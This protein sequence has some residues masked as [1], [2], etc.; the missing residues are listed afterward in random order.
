MGCLGHAM[1]STFLDAA[2]G[3]VAALMRARDWSASPLGAP[4]G[5]PA[6]LQTIASLVLH[7]TTPMFVAWGPRR[8]MLY[9]DAYLSILGD[10]HPAALG[11]PAEEVWSES[12]DALGPVFARTFAGEAVHGQDLPVRIRRNGH[13]EQAWFTFSHTP[14]F[15]AGA[16]QGLFCHIVETTARVRAE[17]LH[18]QEKERLQ[19]WFEQAP[20]LI[21]VLR[22]PDHVIEVANRAYREFTGHRPLIGLKVREALPDLEGQGFVQLLDRVY[23]TGQAYV[24]RAVPSKKRRRPGGP[25]ENRLVDFVYQPMRDD[26]G[27]VSGI[28]AQGV[29]VTESVR[30]AEALRQSEGLLRAATEGRGFGTW[31]FDFTTGCGRCSPRTAEAIGIARTEFTA[32]DWMDGVH[33]DDRQAVLQAWVAAEGSDSFETEFRT[34]APAEDGGPRWLLSRAHVERDDEGRPLRAAGIAFDVTRRW[35][36]QQALAEQRARERAYLEHLPVGVW[37]LDA[38]GRIEYGNAE[39]QRIWGGARYV[40]PESFAEYKA[41]WHGSGEPL[42]NEDWAAWRAMRVG[43]AVLNEELDIECFDGTRKTILNSA[44][45]LRD[46][47]GRIVG[48]VVLNQDITEAKRNEARV[49]EAQESMRS[50]QEGMQ[51]AMTIAAAATWDW[52]MRADHL[53]WSRSHFELLGYP[54]PPDGLAPVALWLN[55]VALEDTPRMQAE[56]NRAMAERDIFRS[57]HRRRRADGSTIWVSAAGRFFYDEQGEPIR[58]TGVLFDITERKRAEQALR[59]ADRRKD[60]FLATLAH[61]LRNPLAP[62]RSGLAVLRMPQVE[63]ATRQRMLGLME[64]QVQHVVRLVDDLLE[65]SRITRGKIELRREALELRSVVH[66]SVDAAQPLLQAARHELRVTLPP[67]PVL[68][69]ADA[70]RIAQV[71]DNLL[72][73]AIKYTPEGGRIHIELASRDGHADLSVQDNGTGIPPE[74]LERVFELFTQVD[75][76][77]GRAKGGLGIGLALVRQLVHMHGG[78]V[79]AYS[80]GVGTGARFVVRLPLLDRQDVSAAPAAASGPSADAPRLRVLVVDDNRDAADSLAIVLEACGHAVCT[81]YGGRQALEEVPR[82]RPDWVLLDIGMPGIDGNEVARRL[83]A[84]PE[85][86]RLKLVAVTGWGQEEDR[87]LTQAAGFDAHLVKPVEPAALLDL[88]SS[89]I[90][91]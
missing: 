51:L 21:V 34:V 68:V 9:N 35:R 79:H 59:E 30:A 37:F 25:P 61:E 22:G 69:D 44:V 17:R 19:Q 72:N 26:A 56:W 52:D 89:G 42:R 81:A 85:G 73:N 45:P 32:Q 33:P 74:M 84:T 83:R 28:F 50:A 12:W 1:T 66:A 43:E 55:T 7:A 58:F 86:A 57:E 48:T 3:E 80:E 91:A 4:H 6:P 71:L 24:G 13:E 67:H 20:S 16:V 41:W 65:V 18:V 5:W 47:G 53:Q 60:E 10:K 49:R 8:A 39:A 38:Q 31:E 82:F 88:L 77:L 14:V 29:D 15:E 64:R 46:A 40:A 70:T 75:R 36:A 78:T 23:A 62:I 87:R 54:P 11:R 76:T 90:R 63:D 2:P 27:Q